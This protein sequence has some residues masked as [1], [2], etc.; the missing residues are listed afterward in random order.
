MLLP[1]QPNLSDILLMR[2][3]KREDCIGSLCITEIMQILANLT[4]DSGVTSEQK[5]FHLWKLAPGELR[6]SVAL[7]H[8]ALVLHGGFD[9]H[10]VIQQ[11][12]LIGGV[13]APLA[14][15]LVETRRGCRS[16]STSAQV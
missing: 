10:K 9:H 12:V 11:L 8:D 3:K 2:Q 1:I 5:R 7:H 16:T 4:R 6:R 15:L 13:Q 14:D